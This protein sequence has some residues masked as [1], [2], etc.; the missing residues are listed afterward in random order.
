MTFWTFVAQ[1]VNFIVFVVILRFLL[2]KPARRFMRERRD[3]MEKQ[4]RQA[5]KK[6]QE[7]K[8]TLAEAEEERNALERERDGILRQARADGEARQDQML[9]EAEAKAKKRLEEFRRIM[10][11]ERDEALDSVRDEVKA[12]SLR[13]VRRMLN[14]ASASLVDRAVDRV[15]ERL[16]DLGSEDRQRA[17]AALEERSAGVAVRASH[18]LSDEQRERLARVVAE[19]LGVEDAPLDIEEDESLVAGL[20]VEAGEVVVEAHWR[21]IIDEA[22]EAEKEGA[23]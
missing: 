21:S 3:E 6:E 16:G 8:E 12:L 11:R 13:A 1:A 19:G 4:L 23:E 7:A 2:F 14:D 18:T 5:E 9:K 20:A 22:F 15:R 17:R 10:E